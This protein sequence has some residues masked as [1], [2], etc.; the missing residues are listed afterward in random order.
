LKLP[1]SLQAAYRVPDA[2]FSATEKVKKVTADVEADKLKNQL[3]KRFAI[4]IPAM[5]N[6][7]TLT[8]MQLKIL[9]FIY[10]MNNWKTHHQQHETGT[11]KIL[12][13]NTKMWF[14][15]Q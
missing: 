6:A 4:T 5:R 8:V 9:L 3:T 7:F 11:I 13:N 14:L 2:I 10:Y 1:S 15:S 12:A